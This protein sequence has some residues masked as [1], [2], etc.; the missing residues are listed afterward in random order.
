[1][2]SLIST[3]LAADQQ[4]KPQQITGMEQP[5]P[6]PDGRSALLYKKNQ[7]NPDQPYHEIWV[8]STEAPGK[9][10]LLFEYGRD[11][12]V[13]WSPDSTMVAIT[14]AATST[15]SFV[16]VFR[17]VSLTM[18]EE[19]KEVAQFLDTTFFNNRNIKADHRYAEVVSWSQDSKSLLVALSGH[20][21]GGREFHKKVRIKIPRKK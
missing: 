20:G 6:S 21:D 5:I 9:E 12:N 10:A 8:R 2:L 14:H 17:V 1:M 4:A 11:A 3:A 16:F 18:F 15:D 19:V 13:L 7:T